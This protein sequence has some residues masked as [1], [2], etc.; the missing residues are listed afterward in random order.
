MRPK[1]GG[2]EDLA[3]YHLGVAVNSSIN[4]A[5]SPR[6]SN[7]AVPH[8]SAREPA[9]SSSGGGGAGG[10]APPPAMNPD[11]S[12]AVS[13][14]VARL[15]EQDSSS[16]NGL[17]LGVSICF[18]DLVRQVE[19]HCG[20]RGRALTLVWNTLLSTSQATMERFRCV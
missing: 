19:V 14:G 2:Y 17:N 6:R 9:L 16:L 11:G 10:D 18:A 4:R 7:G 1:S 15:A 12:L 3:S 5:A 20:E 13:E 8:V